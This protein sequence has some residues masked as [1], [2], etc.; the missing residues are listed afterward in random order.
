MFGDYEFEITLRDRNRDGTVDDDVQRG[1]QYE[2]IAQTMTISVRP[3]NDAPEL[4]PNFDPL[5]FTVME[6]GTIEILVTGDQA[7]PG[8][9]DVFLPGPSGA[10]TDES[11]DLTPQPGGNQTVSMA[12]HERS[13][14]RMFH[15]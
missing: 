10:P 6:D 12:E 9:L 8:L 7:N 14:R 11:A 15:S 13:I 4:N 3:I 1:D 2:S 5:S